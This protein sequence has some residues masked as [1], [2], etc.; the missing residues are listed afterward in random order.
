M[1]FLDEPKYEKEQE[2]S[3][4]SEVEIA[5]AEAAKSVLLVQVSPLFETHS[6]Y[7]PNLKEL[8]PQFIDNATLIH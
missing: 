1:V 8:K 4:P 7:I 6:L 3:G 5:E 2:R